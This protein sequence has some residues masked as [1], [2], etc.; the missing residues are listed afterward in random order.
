M[1]IKWLLLIA[2]TML[3]VWSYLHFSD[4]QKQLQDEVVMMEYG[5]L[6]KQVWSLSDAQK[7]HE[8]AKDSS[9]EKIEDKRVQQRDAAR[10]TKIGFWLAVLL[11]IVSTGYTLMVLYRVGFVYI[12]REE[13]YKE[14]AAAWR[15]RFPPKEPLH[16]GDETN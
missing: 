8:L 4:K 15:R 16:E 11:G 2:G 13:G 3:F 14:V 6:D 10:K 7:H 12:V 1:L 9:Y 5:V